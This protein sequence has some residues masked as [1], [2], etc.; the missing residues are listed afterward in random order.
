MNKYQ[1]I[2][3]QDVLNLLMDINISVM[4]PTNI[5]SIPC[6]SN[7]LETSKYQVRKYIKE[8][9]NDGL[10]DKDCYCIDPEYSSLCYFGFKITDKA[11]KLDIYKEKE[12]QERNLI[13]KIWGI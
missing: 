13:N 4:N 9:K 7:C 2:T 12:Q 1:K 5:M 8:L 3:K 6:I 10:V 11:K